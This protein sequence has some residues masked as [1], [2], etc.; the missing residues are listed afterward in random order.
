M[1]SSWQFLPIIGLQ[2]CNRISFNSF[3]V[4]CALIQVLF[5]QKKG[6]RF[7]ITGQHFSF[8]QNAITACKVEISGHLMI[9]MKILSRMLIDWIVICVLYN[10]YHMY[11]CISIN[12][13]MSTVLL[14]NILLPHSP[15]L[16]ARIAVKSMLVVLIDYWPLPPTLRN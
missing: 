11:S 14:Q 3:F 15:V 7:T 1:Q 16:G 6:W 13:Y 2:A 4:L 8:E 9:S 12:I 5:V 10:S